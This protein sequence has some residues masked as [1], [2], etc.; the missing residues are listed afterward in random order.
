[1]GSPAPEGPGLEELR[2]EARHQQERLDLYRAKVYR[3]GPT[4]PQR[5]R[6]LERMAEGAHARLRAAR[7]AKDGAPAPVAGPSA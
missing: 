1:M 5:L 6:E 3:G 7:Q 4:T 2:A